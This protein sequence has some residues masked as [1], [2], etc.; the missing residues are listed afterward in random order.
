ME[1]VGIKD[2]DE[3]PTGKVKDKLL[4]LLAKGIIGQFKANITKK[5]EKKRYIYYLFKFNKKNLKEIEDFAKS[6]GVSERLDSAKHHIFDFI[7]NDYLITLQSTG[8][9]VV[10]DENGVMTSRNKGLAFEPEIASLLISYCNVPIDE[11]DNEVVKRIMT[12][13][14][15]YTITKVD[16]IAGTAKKRKDLG[17][18]PLIKDSLVQH[19]IGKIIADITITGKTSSSEGATE[20]EV[21]L[22]L[23][24]DKTVK[25]INKGIAS[26]KSGFFTKNNFAK[27]NPEPIKPNSKADKLLNLLGMEEGSEERQMF[28]NIFRNYKSGATGTAT[29]R[30]MTDKINERALGKMIRCAVGYGYVFVHK[31]GK[32]NFTIQNIVPDVVNK[33]FGRISKAIANFGHSGTKQFNMR[34]IF[35]SGNQC[36]ICLRHTHGGEFPNTFL[37]DWI[38]D[39]KSK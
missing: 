34:L 37:L 24:K 39:S 25:Y 29:K 19:N 20:T 11:V 30:D 23:K 26:G 18:F 16:Y 4:A 31:I 12:S 6:M 13:S 22:S 15:L 17:K 33:K 7:V 27:E 14:G 2:I 21:Y 8:S 3:I 9:K 28:I 38:Q 1:E 32:N 5:I 10:N 36:E 35:T